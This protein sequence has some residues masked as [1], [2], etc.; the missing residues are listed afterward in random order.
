M[1]KGA[2]CASEAPFNSRIG[3]WP[4][5]QALNLLEK[6]ATDKHSSMLQTI[7]NYG[8]KKLIALAQN[9]TREK[10]RTL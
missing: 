3:S 6:L 10:N 4:Y 2:G 7:V 8:L 9:V 1:S 5:P